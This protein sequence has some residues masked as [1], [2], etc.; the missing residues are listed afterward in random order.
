MTKIW[1][2]V[3]MEPWEAEVRYFIG[4]GISP[5]NARI[6]TIMH[7]MYLGDFRPLSAATKETQ[8]QLHKAILSTLMQMIDE[9]RLQ[10]KAKGRGRP[11]KPEL[12]AEQFLSVL[13]YERT[14]L[15]GRT[16]DERFDVIADVMG[17]SP[18][19]IRRAVATL[20]KAAAKTTRNPV[21]RHDN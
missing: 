3:G 16:S 4:R 18:E 13:A 11:R 17:T 8:G 19:N 2:R 7:W 1:D 6:F 14:S 15:K 5:E 12:L 20:R 21:R 10:V 9:G